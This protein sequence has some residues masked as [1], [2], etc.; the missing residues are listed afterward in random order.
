MKP[1][2]NTSFS[3]DYSTHPMHPLFYINMLCKPCTSI[4]QTFSSLKKTQRELMASKAAEMMLRCVF[5]GSISMHDMEIERRPYH[6]NCSCA[7]H[8]LK[9]VYSTACLQHRKLSFP[10]KQ[11]W[12]N[13]S[14]STSAASRLSSSHQHS[15]PCDRTNWQEKIS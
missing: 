5:E 2:Q 8:S 9:G 10:K 3:L 1:H 15:L 12:S 13:F 7:L 14:L 6:R 11:S 4:K